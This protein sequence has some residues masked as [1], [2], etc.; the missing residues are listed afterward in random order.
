MN[1]PMY[2]MITVKE[3]GRLI[4]IKAGEGYTH[5]VIYPVEATYILTKQKPEFQFPDESVQAKQRLSEGKRGEARRLQQAGLAK[6]A[7]VEDSIFW[8]VIRTEIDDVE[9][10]GDAQ[11]FIVNGDNKT[12]DKK[13]VTA[14]VTPQGGIAIEVL[15]TKSGAHIRHVDEDISGINL[16]L[17]AIMVRRIGNQDPKSVTDLARD[18]LSR[19]EAK[20]VLN[21]LNTGNIPDILDRLGDVA[22]MYEE[23]RKTGNII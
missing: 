14:Q 8:P 13:W 16:I 11:T 22:R 23:F 7:S 10:T 1:P 12:P 6:M 15:V 5:A 18:V 4:Q 17:A 9:A 19:E 21:D 2:P 3:T 20:D